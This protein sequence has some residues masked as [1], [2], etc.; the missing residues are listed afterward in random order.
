MTET[1]NTIS[2]PET[3]EPLQVEMDRRRRAA[4]LLLREGYSQTSIAS[5]LH[6]TQATISRWSRQM[7]IT[8]KRGAPRREFNPDAVPESLISPEARQTQAHRPTFLTADQIRYVW[9]Q[10]PRWTWPEFAAA[11]SAAYGVRYS[12]S[13]AS[14]LLAQLARKGAAA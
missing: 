5:Y 4:E 2:S 8:G 1:Q 7:G 12:R 6:V 13:Q 11:L 14:A 10:K 3:R 9:A